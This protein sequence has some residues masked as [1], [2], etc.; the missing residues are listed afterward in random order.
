MYLKIGECAQAIA[1]GFG[2]SPSQAKTL[3][4]SCLSPEETALVRDYPTSLR[5]PSPTAFER[6][7]RHGFESAKCVH[8]F[9]ARV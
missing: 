8:L 1:K 6:I 5:A 3:S 2:L 7:L 9:G 4:E